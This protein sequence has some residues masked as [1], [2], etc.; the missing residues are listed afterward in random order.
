MM[1]NEK[2]QPAPVSQDNQSDQR[3]VLVMDDE[4]QKAAQSGS[5]CSC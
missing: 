1:K 4:E 3:K 2:N 5:G